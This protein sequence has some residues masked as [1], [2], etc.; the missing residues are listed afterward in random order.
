MRTTEKLLSVGQAAKAAGVHRTTVDHWIRNGYLAA[1]TL[2]AA[3]GR[4]GVKRYIR[5]GDLERWLAAK[6]RQ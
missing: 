1:L 2:P 3:P 4:V 6:G 5:E